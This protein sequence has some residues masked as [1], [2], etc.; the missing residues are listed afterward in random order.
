MDAIAERLRPRVGR[1][2][3]AFNELCD[4]TLEEAVDELIR[5]GVRHITVVTTML[6][7]G[8]V[9]SEVEIPESVRALQTARPE[10]FIR[11]AWPFDLDAVAALLAGACSAETETLRP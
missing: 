11:Y 3:V 10:V 7:P 1:V 6:T 5:D 2:V 9:H 4:A 8:G